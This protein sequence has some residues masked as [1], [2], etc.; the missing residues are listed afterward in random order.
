MQ[1]YHDYLKPL[2]SRLQGY[3]KRYWYPPLFAVLAALDAFLVVIPTDGLLVSSSLAV[4]RRWVLHGF[5]AALGSTIGAFILAYLARQY[6]LPWVEQSYP[7]IV[8]FE[9]WK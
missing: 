4:P 2:F 3:A 1:S 7:D 8:S 9:T 5:C 6:G